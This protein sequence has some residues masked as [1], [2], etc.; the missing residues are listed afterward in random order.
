MLMFVTSQA[1]STSPGVLECQIARRF[2]VS[3]D[4]GDVKIGWGKTYTN[5]LAEF[6]DDSY[7]SISTASFGMDEAT[8]EWASDVKAEWFILTSNGK[9]H[10]QYRHKFALI[11]VAI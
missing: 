6:T 10:N 9:Y 5:V 1:L 2:W 7:F 4:L 11:S 8:H 3:W